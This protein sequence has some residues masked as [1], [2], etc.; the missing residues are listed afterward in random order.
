MAGDQDVVGLRLRDTR[1][2][3]ADAGLRNELDADTRARVDGLEVMD[4]LGQVLDRID[5]V[6]RRRRDE[7]HARLGV[8]Q[9]GDQARDLQARELPALAWLGALGD[10]DLELVR[11]LQVAGSDTESR[12]GD[13]LHAIVAAHSACVVVHVGVFATLA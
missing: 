4:E 6:V 3:G 12:R 11:P 5:V 1:G 13:L 9:P 7:L 8:A 2:D 10:L